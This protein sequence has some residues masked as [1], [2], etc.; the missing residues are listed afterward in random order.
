[1]SQNKYN[2]ILDETPKAASVG[3]SNPSGNVNDEGSSS[4]ALTQETGQEGHTHTAE[5]LANSDTAVTPGSRMA[6]GK[7]PVLTNSSATADPPAVPNTMDGATPREPVSVS[8]DSPPHDAAL[9]AGTANT[10]QKVV[11]LE[12]RVTLGDGSEL[13]EDN[14]PAEQKEGSVDCVSAP[15]VIEET[16]K[17]GSVTI[18]SNHTTCSAFSFQNSLLFELD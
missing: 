16:N 10:A 9:D 8:N 4:G 1:Q 7:G 2:V 13:D 11:R 14:L 12:E 3:M 5:G 18:I 15:P 17:D 6:S